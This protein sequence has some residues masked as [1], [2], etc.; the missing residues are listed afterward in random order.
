MAV[1]I[2]I[3]T[4]TVGGP[5]SLHTLSSIYC[6][7]IFYDHHSGW[8]EVISHCSLIYISLIIS[9]PEHL[10]MYLLAICMSSL[11]KCLFRSSTH[12]L[13]GLF[14]LGLLSIM[15]AFPVAQ[16]VKNP[17]AMWETCVR[18]L[19]WEDSLEKG[20][21]THSSILAWRTPRTV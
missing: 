12:L 17:P 10:L 16:L 8:C 7:W 14:V 3:P 21:A 20:M 4:N 2:Y 5:L 11:E 1:P 13:I 19:G 15:R 9:D 18:S 6:L